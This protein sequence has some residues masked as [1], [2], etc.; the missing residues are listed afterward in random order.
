M[1]KAR[2]N[3]HSVLTKLRAERESRNFPQEILPQ[4]RKGRV[5]LD[6]L[7]TTLFPEGV[8]F[9]VN[10]EPEDTLRIDRFVTELRKAG[11]LKPVDEFDG[12][13][14]GI[15]C[16]YMIARMYV[17]RAFEDA[18]SEETYASWHRAEIR[19]AAKLNEKF[20]EQLQEILLYR[21]EAAESLFWRTSVT[22]SLKCALHQLQAETA[23]LQRFAGRIPEGRGDIWRIRF[24]RTLGFGWLDLTGRKPARTEKKDLLFLDFVEAAFETGSG[25]LEKSWDRSCRTAI[26]RENRLP[27]EERWNFRRLIRDRPL[28]RAPPP[29]KVDV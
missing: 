21:N 1:P 29:E 26:E 24:A 27:V 4:S 17:Y 28:F 20:E 22:E 25:R 8:S 7:K 6:V 13:E 19:A 5:D 14:H 11:R 15:G 3:L 18:E 12:S 23:E 9:V 16:P 10:R 2:T